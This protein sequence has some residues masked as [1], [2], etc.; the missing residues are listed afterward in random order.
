M[1][2]GV[3]LR[4]VISRDPSQRHGDAQTRGPQVGG[5]VPAVRPDVG[6]SRVGCCCGGSGC[7]GGGDGV[8]VGGRRALA[9][10]DPA[11]AAGGAPARQPAFVGAAAARRAHGRLGLVAAQPADAQALRLL[12]R[13]FRGGCSGCGGGHGRRPAGRLGTSAVLPPVPASS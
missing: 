1:Q 8:A 7:G 6:R 2:A 9:V 11:V 5:H 13:L 10:G 4:R 12:R 3:A